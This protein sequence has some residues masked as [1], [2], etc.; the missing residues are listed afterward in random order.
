MK[1]TK[2]TVMKTVTANELKQSAG[3]VM[4]DAQHMPVIVEKY[5][6]PHAVILSHTDYLE[7][8]RMKYTALKMGIASG[9]E[10]GDAGVFNPDELIAAIKAE[11]Q[12]SKN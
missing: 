12:S 6:R 1:Q 5:G 10:S 8:E 11:T 3:R 9:I 4:D 2:V 7:Y